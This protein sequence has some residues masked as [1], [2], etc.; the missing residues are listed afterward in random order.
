ME[1]ERNKL[2]N[3]GDSCHPYLRKPAAFRY[4]TQIENMLFKQL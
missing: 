4:A 1:N 3:L 2:F